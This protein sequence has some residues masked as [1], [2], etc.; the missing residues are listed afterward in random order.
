MSGGDTARATRVLGD[1]IAA[2]QGGREV[3]VGMLR[4]KTRLRCCER[5][6]SRNLHADGVYFR[7]LREKPVLTPAD[8]KERLNFA[9]RFK[10]KSKAWWIKNVDIHLDNH[11]F[12]VATASRGRRLLAM[13]RVRGVYRTKGKGL[14]PDMQAMRMT[15]RYK[16]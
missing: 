1:M 6:L 5:T 3:T 8:V 4:R 14:A 9:R 7:K 13:R 15:K 2:A 10:G 12:K 11:C 16:T